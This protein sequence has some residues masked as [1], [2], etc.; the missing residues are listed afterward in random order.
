MRSNI[1]A[2]TIKLPQFHVLIRKSQYSLWITIGVSEALLCKLQHLFL[3]R[4]LLP[5]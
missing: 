1:E 4:P 3:S 2:N 5:L